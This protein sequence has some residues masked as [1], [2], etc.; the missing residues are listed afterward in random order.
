[1][2]RLASPVEGMKDHYEVVVV[3]SGYGGAITASRLA[4][5]GREVCLLERGREFQPG[6]YPDTELEA[7]QEFQVDRPEMRLG[8]RTGLYDLRMNDEINVFLG[9]GL[10]G[11]SLVNANVSLRA[12]ER[13]FDDPVWPEGLQADLNSLVQQGYARAEEMLRPVSLPQSIRLKKL[14]ALERSSTQL[15]GRFSRPP[16]NVTFQTGVNHVGVHQQACTLCGDCVSGCNYGSKNTLIMNY[17]PDARNF[18]AEIYTR[19]AVRYLERRDDRWVVHYQLLDTGR[20]R[21]AAPLLFVSA[22]LVVLSAGTLGSTEILLRSRDNGLPLSPALGSRFTGNGDV[23]AF[24]YNSDLEIDGIGWGA[25]DTGNLGP[26]GPTITGV[27]DLRQAPSLEGGMIIE[28]GAVPGGVAGFLP[29][30]LAIVSKFAGTDTDRG[31]FD[32]LRESGREWE[33]LLRGPYYGAVRNTQIYLVMANDDAGGHM[34]LE[35][36]RLRISWERVGDQPIFKAIEK[37][38]IAATKPLG[39]TYVKDPLWTKLFGNDLITVHPLGGCVMAEDASAGVVN[40]KGQVFS[41]SAGT[42]AYDDLY[43]SDGSV[44][45]RPLGVNPLLTISALAERCCA[46]MARDRG[47]TIDYTLPST[48]P[49]PSP[50]PRL[51]IEFT[52]RMAGFVSLAERSDYAAGAALGKEEG[53]SFAFTLTIVSDDLDRMLTLPGHEAKM[54][55]TVEAPALHKDAIAVTEGVFNLFVDDP[56]QIETRQM[57]YRMKLTTEEGRH[58]YFTG[59]KVIRDDPGI[60]VWPDTTTLYVTLFDGESDRS[61]TLGKG[62]LTIRPDDFMRQLT[63]MRV[64]NAKDVAE[65]LEATARFGKF[66]SEVLYRTYAGVFAGP[67]R[68]RADAPPRKR[69]PLRVSSPEVHP[70]RT[71]DGTELLLTRYRGGSKGPVILSHGLGVSSRIFSTDTIESNLLEFLHANGYDVWL[72]DFRASIELPA[73]KTQFTG[74]D[75]ATQDY[76]AAV[77]TVRSATG[78]ESV[79]MVVHCFG[80][81]TFFMAMLAGLQGVRS[82]VASQVATHMK[83]PLVTRLKSGLHVPQ[84][85]EAIGVDSLNAYT[86]D[87]AG[88]LERLYDKALALWPDQEEEECDSAVCHRITFMYSLLY[89]HDQLNTLTH[90]TLHEMFGVA[91]MSS[92]DH[93]ALMVREGRLVAA[94]GQDRYMPHLDRLAVPITFIHGAENGCFLTQGTKETYDALTRANGPGLYDRFVVPNYGHID[95]IFGRKASRDVYPLILRHLEATNQ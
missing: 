62:V 37:N 94:N 1:M 50:P 91:N 25:R 44:I 59:F 47:W 39:G 68:F 2:T 17:L 48:P 9:C 38:L 30:T 87:Q 70:F 20:E 45:P 88:W 54:A 29:E 81:T 86:D 73:S 31:V 41:G 28:E 93:L 14:D 67:T 64:T 12:E 7:I 3:G 22:D 51:G 78:A 84:L 61:P 4:R 21:F 46:L 60:D 92:L 33:S 49:S 66:F 16:I 35:K 95:C 80:S 79:Q 11:T 18:G 24:S 82:A 52:E 53:S 15:K 42:T 26:I 32:L 27:I 58:Y 77:A 65:R 83:A 10:G 5:A 71:D 72:L 8:S 13:V 85:L 19:A 56:D 69:R 90:N 75:I 23:L 36:D 76:P 57:R 40:H 74:D 55:G 63:T 89:E 6:E 43:V 34:T